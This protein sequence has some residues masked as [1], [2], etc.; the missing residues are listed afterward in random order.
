GP[1]LSAQLRE[2]II[3]W[4]F[5]QHMKAAEIAT[6]AGCSESTVYNVLRFHRDYEQTSNPHARSRG[7]PRLLDIGDLNYLSA[8]L[9]ASPTLYLDELQ[10]KLF[11]ARGVD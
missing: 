5:E 6:L 9:D 10:Q 1:Q 8:L 3:V 2:R 4:R 11:D 7:R